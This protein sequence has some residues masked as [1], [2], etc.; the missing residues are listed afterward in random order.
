MPKE[1]PTTSSLWAGPTPH[2]WPWRG[3]LVS[4][5]S[6]P[7]VPRCARARAGRAQGSE[8]CRSREG[9]G[10]LARAPSRGRGIGGAPR[11]A[12][13]GG[14]S[15]HSAWELGT[16][17]HLVPS[18][19]PTGIQR[20]TPRTKGGTPAAPGGGGGGDAAGGVRGA[21]AVEQ[22]PGRCGAPLQPR[23]DVVLWF[24]LGFWVG[25]AR[26][27]LQ[28][29]PRRRGWHQR[30][31]SLLPPPQLGATASTRRPGLCLPTGMGTWDTLS[32]CPQRR[33]P[34]PAAVGAGNPAAVGSH[35]DLMWHHA[36]PQPLPQPGCARTTLLTHCHL[37]GATEPPRG[38]STWHTSPGPPQPPTTPFWSKPPGKHPQHQHGITPAPRPLRPPR[39]TNFFL[40]NLTFKAVVL[41]WPPAEAV[42]PVTAVPSLRPSLRRLLVSMQGSVRQFYS[43]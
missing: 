9:G 42:P 15:H 41:V 5:P 37:L 17:W 18:L 20:G 30:A 38:R 28:R 36:A 32:P 43:Y 40:G 33:P 19:R 1:S 4:S 27:G 7:P 3:A 22:Q 39:S 24:Q 34:A 23:R 10:T 8:C 35:G 14:T 31:A 25:N 21:L 11:A 29:G 16:Q 26:K 2:A 13:A 12:T 6:G